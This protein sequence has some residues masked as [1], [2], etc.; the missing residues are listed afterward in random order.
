MFVGSGLEIRRSLGI[1]RGK[2]DKADAKRIALYGYRIREEITPYRM[3]S[4]SLITLKRLMSLR[5]KLVVHRAGYV[6]NLKEQKRVIKDEEVLVVAQQ[7]MV[8]AI[9]VQIIGIE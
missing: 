8:D 4:K 3:P 9:A 6:A 2:D 7:A 5:R 1:A